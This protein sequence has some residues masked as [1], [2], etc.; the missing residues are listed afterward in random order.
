MKFFRFLHNWE[1]LHLYMLATRRQNQTQNNHTRLCSNHFIK[2]TRILLE[3]ASLI[4]V[5]CKN[6]DRKMQ[7]LTVC[8]QANVSVPI[9]QI[10]NIHY[11]KQR[12]Q[13]T[14]MRH[15][16]CD[17]KPTR[18]MAINKNTLGPVSEEDIE[19]VQQCSCDTRIT[20]LFKEPAVRNSIKSLSDVEINF[21]N[22]MMMI[23][24]VEEILTKKEELLNSG[25]ILDKPKLR[26]SE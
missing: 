7:C 18:M 6:V 16:R 20:Q 5:F 8:K 15:P 23:T 10:I 25:A 1:R 3:V 11:E 13:D 9:R 17:R 14:T 26:V 19:K 12:A 21:V 4:M 2:A 22:L 24:G